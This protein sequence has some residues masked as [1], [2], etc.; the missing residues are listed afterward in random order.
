MGCRRTASLVLEV[1]VLRCTA[2]RRFML[3]KNHAMYY[4]FQLL[5]FDVVKLSCLLRNCGDLALRS[6]VSM[7]QANV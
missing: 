3:A 5:A 4:N 7:C 6:R 1:R 2:L